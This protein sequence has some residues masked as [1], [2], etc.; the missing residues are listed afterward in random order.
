VPLAL[1]SVAGI[2]GLLWASNVFVVAMVTG[3]EGRV[4][5]LRQLAQPATIGLVLVAGELGLLAWLRFLL[6]QSLRIV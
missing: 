1:W 6:E 4:R 2:V 5:S 3:Y